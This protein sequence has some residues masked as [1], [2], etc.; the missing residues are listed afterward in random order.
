MIFLET[1]Y[2]F[3]IRMYSQWTWVFITS[4]KVCQWLATGQWFSPGTPVSSTN[5]TKILLKVAL[6]TINQTDFSQY[7]SYESIFFQKKNIPRSFLDQFLW[8]FRSQ[9]QIGS[10]FYH[11]FHIILL[12]KRLTINFNLNILNNHIMCTFELQLNWRLCLNR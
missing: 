7:I 10:F 2:R 11:N 1:I 9:M 12:F 5:I 8:H 3:P 6:N 4:D